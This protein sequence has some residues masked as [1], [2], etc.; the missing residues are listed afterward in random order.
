MF[1]KMEAALRDP[2]GLLKLSTK[3]RQ[4]ETPKWELPIK[5]PFWHGLNVKGGIPSPLHNPPMHVQ[6]L[7][8]GRRAAQKADVEKMNKEFAAQKKAKKTAPKKR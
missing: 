5:F 7:P 3:C 8:H 6:A 4:L 2:G 1:Q